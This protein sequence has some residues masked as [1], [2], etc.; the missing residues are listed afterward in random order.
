MTPRARSGDD[1]ALR[2]LL[3]EP[4]ATPQL[5][6]M[7][8]A[9]SGGLEAAPQ[10]GEA[11]ALAAF[12][13]LVAEPAG[14][15]SFGRRRGLRLTAA[16]AS[17]AVLVMGGGV[18]A[19]A[20][21][22]LPAGAQRVAHNVLQAVGVQ[23]PGAT[24]TPTNGPDGS[25]PPSPGQTPPAAAPTH[26]AHPTQPAHPSGQPSTLPTPGNA[27]P[28]RHHGNPTPTA[29]TRPTPGHGK[30][31]AAPVTSGRKT[32]TPPTHPVKANDV[33]HGH[34]RAITR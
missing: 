23:V 25:G 27:G 1:D 10:P 16:I 9:L 6:D 18:A 11:A 32:P 24:A 14:V 13:E 34:A 22:A 3:A 29:T 8:A 26:P 19:A 30:P 33:M 31:T 2:R 20:A 7:L 17:S 12:R 28:S 21:G 5:H 15:Y 4:G